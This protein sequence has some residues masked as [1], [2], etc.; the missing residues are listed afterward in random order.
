M[1]LPLDFNKKNKATCRGVFVVSIWLYF[2]YHVGLGVISY[3]YVY[4]L[5]FIFRN[6]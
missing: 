5:L 6:G 2:K 1:K 4:K 3:L